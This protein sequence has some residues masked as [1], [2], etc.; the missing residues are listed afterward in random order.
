MIG[1]YRLYIQTRIIWFLEYRANILFG[2]VARI[3]VPTLQMIVWMAVA[4]ANGGQLDRYS[5]NDFVIYYLVW[6]LVSDTV[7]G[8]NA[9]WLSHRI[10]TGELS[11]LLL[12]PLHPIHVCFA[13]LIGYKCV[14][15]PM[16][17]IAVVILAVVFGAQ[18]SV[19]VV[20]FPLFIAALFLAYMLNFYVRWFASI[21]GFWTTET[22]AL[23][24]ILRGCEFFLGGKIA[25]LSLMPSALQTIG[26]LLPFRWVFVFPVELFLGHLSFAQVAEG[27]SALI[28]WLLVLPPLA[29]ALW[30]IGI[31]HYSAVGG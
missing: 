30:N 21:F 11:A 12:R 18:F 2:T 9:I 25:P 7:S 29:S 19:N 27:F 5:V 10:R 28:V 14:M 26:A 3:V 20:Y 31:R 22:V 6:M 13:E 15:L 1:V 16:T 4:R 23:N 24:G 17:G 8:V